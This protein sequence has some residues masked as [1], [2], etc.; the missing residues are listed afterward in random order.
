MAFFSL[1][2][3]VEEEVTPKKSSKLILYSASTPNLS[4]P[5]YFENVRK[6]ADLERQLEESKKLISVLSLPEQSCPT[7]TTS[8]TNAAQSEPDASEN[9]ASTTPSTVPAQSGKSSDLLAHLSKDQLITC[10]KRLLVEL[11]LE[12]QRHQRAVRHEKD[13]SDRNFKTLSS[14]IMLLMSHID[15]IKNDASN[16][17]L[18]SEIHRKQKEMN[19]LDDL[20]DLDLDPSTLSEIFGADQSVMFSSSGA[21]DLILRSEREEKASRPIS[22]I[23]LPRAVAANLQA[24]RSMPTRELVGKLYSFCTTVVRGSFSYVFGSHKVNKS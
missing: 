7:S 24:Y 16:S 9:Q 18:A 11:H 12:R 21:A 22:L 19:S 13:A 14:V 20:L 1:R 4:Q 5:D 2:K 15:M 6:I 23:K 17:S 3:L 10:V 8:D